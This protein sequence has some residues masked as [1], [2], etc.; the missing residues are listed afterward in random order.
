MPRRHVAFPRWA[1]HRVA[2]APRSDL[3]LEGHRG[4]SRSEGHPARTGSI[5]P[6]EGA[7]PSPRALPGGRGSARAVTPVRAGRGGLEGGL[8]DGAP[9]P[10]PPRGCR[11]GL[12]CEAG[13]G[14]ELWA[15][16]SGGPGLS[17]P[18]QLPCSCPYAGQRF[19]RRD[20]A[21]SPGARCEGRCCSPRALPAL[22][23]FNPPVFGLPR[24]A[25]RAGSP[26][27]VRLPT[28]WR[29]SLFGSGSAPALGV[30]GLHSVLH[31]QQGGSVPSAV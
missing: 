20:P 19:G 15:R 3:A 18:G 5:H 29:L 27:W 2:P 23:A 13:G 8:R 1:F 10:A 22:P 28:T 16:G 24:C 31:L 26:V 7:P 12:V 11:S 30:V 6:P 17:S 9:R 21:R 14:A 4:V 25:T